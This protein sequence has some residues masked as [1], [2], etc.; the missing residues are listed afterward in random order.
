M[1]LCH[2]SS[3]R[4][5]H[6]SASPKVPLGS[7]NGALFQQFA[8]LSSIG[9]H[10]IARLRLRLAEDYATVFAVLAEAGIL[11][12]KL[13]DKMAELARFRNLLVH[14]YCRIDHEDVYRRMRDRTRTLEEFQN[15]IGNSLAS[16]P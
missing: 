13:A 1:L 2:A 9:N 3:S 7:P 16:R 6:S 11:S 5:S 4:A 8:Q 15:T 10:L 12:R 14:V